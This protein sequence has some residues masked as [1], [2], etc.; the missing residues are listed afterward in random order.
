MPELCP[1]FQGRAA[2]L[3]AEHPVK[4][5]DG[6]EA[7]PVGH[8]GHVQPRLLQQRN[9][10]VQP[11]GVHVVREADLQPVA[12]NVGDMAGA[13]MQGLAKILQGQS[14]LIVLGA[15]LQQ[16][17]HGAAQLRGGAKFHAIK[18]LSEKSGLP[19]YATTIREDLLDAVGDKVLNPVPVKL[20]FR[21]E[22]AIY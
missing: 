14:L 2:V 7:G 12:E 21:S 3:L 19:V 15:V 18:E 1:V 4:G 11:Q 16:L 22:W 6:R 5:A 10:L 9:S 13:D 17:G 20:H 8:L